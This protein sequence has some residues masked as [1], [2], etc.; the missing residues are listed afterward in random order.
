MGMKKRWE[1]QQN[2]SLYRGPFFFQGCFG[3]E[4]WGCEDIFLFSFSLFWPFERYIVFKKFRLGFSQNFFFFLSSGF[5][6]LDCVNNS[7]FPRGF[8]FPSFEDR[9]RSCVSYIPLFSFFLREKYIFDYKLS[10]SLPLK[11]KNDMY[12]AESL[13]A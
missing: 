5:I 13:N 8:F 2:T 11:A 7:N 10:Y 1:T 12:P 4:L 9:V 3:K 6:S